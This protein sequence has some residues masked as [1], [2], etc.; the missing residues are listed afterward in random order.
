V[1]GQRHAPTALP[2]AKTRYPLYR[3]LGGPQGRSGRVRK[4]LPTPGFYFY[5]PLRFDPRT[6]QLVASRYTDWATRLIIFSCTMEIS[7]SA[8]SVVL[9]W[10]GI[11]VVILGECA[12]K[13]TEDF[14][15]NF[16]STHINTGTVV[17]GTIVQ[18]PFPPPPPTFKSLPIS[19]SRS[20]EIWVSQ[21]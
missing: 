8:K 3:R 2:P 12:C 9:Q 18:P 5:S 10:C 16:W 4:I 17:R 13:F 14:L 19:Y 20:Y 11:P 7:R 15:G 21:G 1:S 6:V